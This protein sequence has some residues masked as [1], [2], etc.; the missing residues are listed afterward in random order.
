MDTDATSADPHRQLRRTRRGLRPLP[1]QDGA[2]VV[3][4]FA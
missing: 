4:G 1:D 3:Q 2:V